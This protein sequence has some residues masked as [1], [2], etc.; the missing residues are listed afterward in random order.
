LTLEHVKRI[1]IRHRNHLH[2]GSFRGF[3]TGWGIFNG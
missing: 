1:G 3:N 2:P